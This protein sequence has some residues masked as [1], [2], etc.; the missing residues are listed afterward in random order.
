MDGIFFRLAAR[1]RENVFNFI[2]CGK[3][4]ALMSI[5]VYGTDGRQGTIKQRK[6]T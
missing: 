4:F 2:T 5:S 6:T 1:H 3:K